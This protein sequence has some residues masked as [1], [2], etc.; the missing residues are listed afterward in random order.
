MED[1]SYMNIIKSLQWYA[2]LSDLKLALANY[3]YRI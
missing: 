3:Y 1:T 2:I